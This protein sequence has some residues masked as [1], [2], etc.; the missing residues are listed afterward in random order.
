MQITNRLDNDA[1]F[2]D[3]LVHTCSIKNVN[4]ERVLKLCLTSSGTL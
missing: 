2:D 1:I 4:Q 3:I